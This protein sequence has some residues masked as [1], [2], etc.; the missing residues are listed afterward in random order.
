MSKS[1]F[2]KRQP[3]LVVISDVH[4]GTF[5]CHAMEL[6]KYLKSIHPKT[7]ILNGDIVDIWQFKKRYWPKAH[8]LV[9][10]QIMGMI[11]KGIDVYYITG[12]HDELLRKF[13]DFQLGS[14][15][16]VN[17]LELD[18]DGKKTWFFHGDVFDVSMQYSK[19]L[20]KI[21]G[22]SYDMLVRLNRAVNFILEKIGKEKRSFSKTIKNS[23]KSA[24]K[25]I[26]NFE[27]STAQ[28]AIKNGCHYVVCGHIHQPV[29][30]KLWHNG[31][32]VIYLNSGDWVENLTSLEYD[33]G[34]WIIYNYSND[35]LAKSLNE[36]SH[37]DKAIMKNNEL[38]Q[39]LLEEFNVLA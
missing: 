22:V 5:G 25:F 8:M 37:H 38:F 31:E 35:K 13:T 34:E 6:L 26:N 12:N 32:D 20:A 18:L 21:G 4:L 39:D 15:Q 33:A 10:K 14:F 28:M 9:L 30:K 36:N 17:Q 19:W 16:I 29:I 24:V 11:A 23:V 1:K 2:N 7:L 3:E 27:A